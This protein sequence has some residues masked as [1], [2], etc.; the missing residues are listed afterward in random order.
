[1]QYYVYFFQLFKNI[2]MI[3]S[4]QKQVVTYIWH[5]GHSLPTS[6]LD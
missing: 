6:E 3:I 5:M 2:N 1:M 4:L